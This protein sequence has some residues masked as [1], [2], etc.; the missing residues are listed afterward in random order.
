MVFMS[1]SVLDWQPILKSWLQTLSVQQNDT[2]WQSFESIYQVCENRFTW[3][4]FESIYEACERG[5]RIFE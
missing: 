1:S 5:K 2:L 3:F 4:V